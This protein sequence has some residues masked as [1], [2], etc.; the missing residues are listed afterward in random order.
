M[1]QR[2]FFSVAVFGLLCFQNV[3]AQEKIVDADS[4]FK[5]IATTLQTF[6]GTGRLVDNPGIDGSDLEYFILLLEEFYQQFSRS[7]NGESAMCQFYRDPENSR[8]TIEERAELSFS[9]LGSL[10]NRINRFTKTNEE[11][12]EQVEEQFGTILLNNIISLKV[13]SIS[14]QELPSQEFNES[15]R[16]SFLDSECI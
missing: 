1:T 11:F 15:E 2:I 8:M 13:S 4:S 6:R 16:I 10:S 12:Q 9:Y 14:Y 5:Y 7:F 3:Q